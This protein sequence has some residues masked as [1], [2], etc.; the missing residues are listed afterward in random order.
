MVSATSIAQKLIAL[1][2]NV[3]RG[4]DVE[5]LSQQDKA[6]LQ[7]IH[8][9]CNEVR[10]DV[11]D[12]EYAQTRDEQLK[13]AKIGRHNISALSKMLLSLDAIFTAADIAECGAYLESLRSALE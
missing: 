6:V 3:S 10:L 4:V 9:A 2:K 8:L 12:Y 11:R 5:A 13:W 1:I 7:Q